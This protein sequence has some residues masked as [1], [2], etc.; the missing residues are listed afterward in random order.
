MDIVRRLSRSEV[1]VR[2]KLPALLA[3]LK[4]LYEEEPS[5]LRTITLFEHVSVLELLINGSHVFKSAV[6][7]LFSADL[8]YARSSCLRFFD[9]VAWRRARPS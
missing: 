9:S 8:R 7:A 6:K 3:H 4:E 5:A 1:F 2:H